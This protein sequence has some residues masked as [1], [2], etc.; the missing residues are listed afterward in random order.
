MK[1]S[2][3]FQLNAASGLKCTLGKT[4]PTIDSLSSI[5][6]L[7]EHKICFC[8][9][10]QFINHNY[11]NFPCFWF[12]SDSFLSA[13]NENTLI[14]L[15][16]EKQQHIKLTKQPNT[17]SYS[18]GFF[19]CSISRRCNLWYLCDYFMVVV[20]LHSQSKKLTNGKK[21]FEQKNTTKQNL[22]IQTN[23]IKKN[24]IFRNVR[25]DEDKKKLT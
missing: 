6:F 22:K 15:Q 25:A 23:R 17:S 1:S 8:F 16:S 10:F 3:S 5:L 11:T 20:F 24:Q 9:H 4:F 19:F 2:K 12:V 18:P 14:V 13:K 21:N 7:F